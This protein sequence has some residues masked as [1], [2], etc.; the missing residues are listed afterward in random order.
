MNRGRSG[1]G[2]RRIYGLVTG[3]VCNIEDPEKR[4]RVKCKLPWLDGEV[5]TH[6]ARVVGQYAGASRG[7]MHIP[8]LE[9]EVMLAF[10]G[11]DPNKPY[12]LGGVYGGQHPVPGPGN[13]DGKNDHKYFRSRVGHDLEFLDTDG[14]EKIRLIDSS[15]NNTMIF[16][17]AEDTIRTKAAT[18]N[19]NI[20]APVGLINMECVD[21]K[22]TTTKSRSVEVGTTHTVSVGTNRTVTAT[23][24]IINMVGNSLT[25]MTA[26]LSASTDTQVDVAMGAM[27]VT[28]GSLETKVQDQVVVEQGPVTKLVGNSKVDAG[29]FF[30]GTA[31]DGASGALTM[32]A[33]ML[34]IKSGG[35]ALVKGSATTVMGGLINSKSV[36][37]EVAN[38]DGPASMAMWMGGLMLCNPKALTFPATKLVD[39]IIGLDTHGPTLPVPS[40]PPLPPIP[41]LPM[42]FT[43]PVILGFKPTVLVNFLPAAPASAVAVGVHPPPVP[44]MWVPLTYQA[45]FKAA[46]MALI[47]AP[48]S[49]MLEMA[50]AKLQA[51]AASTGSPV[52]KEGAMADFVGTTGKD[53]G[54]GGGG[55]F[56]FSSA[57]P[58]FSSGQA[59]LS[60][61]LGCIPL[62]VANA[63]ILMGS[64]S[65]TAGG[66]PMGMAM[67]MGAKSCADP[68][69]PVP[70]AMAATFSN[71]L[72]GISIGDFLGQLAWNAF[73]D[74][75]QGKYI[76]TLGKG[77][78]AV[79]R[80]IAK[81][82]NPSLQNAAQSVN[83]FM[84]GDNCI[85]EG[86]PVDVVSGTM[87]TR[88]TD[89][90]LFS[91][92]SMKYERFYNGK[93]VGLEREKTDFGPGWRHRFD[94]VL[95]ADETT[96]GV[97]SIALRDWEGRILG[98][99]HPLEDGGTDFHPAERL[100]LTRVDGRTYEIEDLAGR[101]RVFKFPG[102]EKGT[103]KGYMPGTKNRARLMAV[104]EPMGGDG[105]QLVWSEDRLAGFVDPAGRVVEITHNRE[106]HVSEI[107][108]TRSPKGDCNIFLAGYEYT[109]EGRLASHI[110]RNK[111]RRRYAYDSKGRLIKETDRN[112]YS[113]HFHYDDQ[114]RCIRTYGDDN[115]YWVE[116]D[117]MGSMT[118]ATD[119]LGGV[120]T[121]AYDENF[122]VTATVDAEGGVTTREYSEEGWLAKLTDANGNATETAYDERGNVVE[123][124]DPNGNKIAYERTPKGH[125][126]EFTDPLGN[127]WRV[128]RDDQ[129]LLTEASTPLGSVRRFERDEVGRITKIVE[130]GGDVKLRTWNA[131]GLPVCDTRTDGVR[132][133]YA[134]DEQG[135][136]TE[137]TEISTQSAKRRLKIK[138][139]AEGR[140]VAI[141]GPAGRRERFELLPD[142]QP[143]KITVGTSSS[144]RRYE[145]WG[146]LVEHIDPLGRKTRVEYDPHHLVTAVHLPGKRS[147]R[148]QRDRL[149]RTVH[150][151]TPDNVDVRY[152][153][154]A[155]GR[156]LEERR[157]DRTKIWEYDAV[158]NVVKLD[159]GAGDTTRFA[160]DAFNRVI[161]AQAEGDRGVKRTYDADGNLVTELQGDEALRWSYDQRR[162][163]SKRTSTWGSK[164]YFQWDGSG[165]V[166]VEDQT[167]N[168]HQFAH[169]PWGN[170]STWRQPGG[171]VRTNQWDVMGRLT[172]DSLA[173]P[174]GDLV[175]DRR[176]TWSE[177]DTIVSI[178]E[179]GVQRKGRDDYSYDDAGRLV[180]WRRDGKDHK[181]EFDEADN[182]L[183]ESGQPDRSYGADRL[184]ED[185]DGNRYRYDGFG[186]QVAMDGKGGS[187]RL[188]Y[189][190]R[191][192][193]VRV[194]MPDSTLVHHQYDAVGRRAESIA[195]HPDGRLTCEKFY[196]DG[197]NLA[198][199]VVYDLAT[200]DITR[201]EEYA[202][203]PEIAAQ[204]LFRVIRGGEDGGDVQYYCTDQRGAAI[205]LTD[206]D[207]KTLWS[208]QYDPYGRCTETGPEAGAQPLRMSGQVYDS[209]SE[210]SWHRFRVFD[211]MSGRFASP[212]PLGLLAGHA[213][214][215]F[216]NDPVKYADPLGLDCSGDAAILRDNMIEAGVDEP[217]YNNHAHHIVQSNSTDP[218]SVA[219]RE[220]LAQHNV[221]IND[222]D[223]G[224]FLPANT[225]TAN[226]ADSCSVPHSRI[227]TN[228]T[229]SE[230]NR[231]VTAQTTE[232][233]VRSELRAIGQEMQSGNWSTQPQ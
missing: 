42:P 156:V 83:D 109:A 108:L 112:G 218:V 94:E 144:K 70:N 99:E 27:T 25:V 124:V 225:A 39:T 136:V 221:S 150:M 107:R 189:D 183:K 223:N 164:C 197:S 161:E 114:N 17:T 191:D 34:T 224:V 208:A 196:W 35:G 125:V 211:P 104:R 140:I 157:P 7:Q 21:L 159:F 79:A 43:G 76:E 13:P 154:D 231:R 75:A 106:G 36:G 98:F 173:V 59:F 63:D 220:H 49:A 165:L 56:T 195:E 158:G 123:M 233:G 93:A 12:V 171:V 166:G 199:R 97:R 230:V 28:Q 147:W 139:D 85:S 16:D 58:M 133:E 148:Y 168:Q 72:V 151:V 163:V 143:T 40:V 126:A 95:V 20:S 23:P 54:G 103:G 90:E 74:Y 92:Q 178:D 115:S 127:G 117:Y 84:G 121:Y 146:R 229:R 209:A 212:D 203:D 51:L 192:R 172:A 113:F 228:H 9:D 137:L 184:L 193:V 38:V 37:M 134:Y 204:P 206:V 160:Y 102:G 60:F 180:G 116:L 217:G 26:S 71:C 88:V 129:G 46:A 198:R 31:A 57:F 182:I 215:T 15:T 187:R 47:T 64:T 80:Q 227:H 101:V 138:R 2:G 149:G 29:S 141:D 145:G 4:G 66:D 77:A 232:A 186:R 87:F 105:I 22:I 155:A 162:R 216:P 130:G 14:G 62:P 19:I 44:W 100:T 52:F 185:G 89:F 153:Y 128:A 118:K 210:L 65:V 222:A 53:G 1:G 201:D 96:D 175:V 86:H 135:L 226:D 200:D 61:I 50:K 169:D 120:T 174:G 55:E 91:A 3:I 132:I 205:Q 213:P 207:G 176:L 142:G 214:Y 219:T 48:F 81:T 111:N 69:I 188:W 119:G 10:E 179:Q 73:S 177:N 68:P 8:E 18:G 131:A 190:G 24:N 45:I 78:D 170:R 202:F 67:P 152:L 82:D 167:G 41:M 110:D 32:M 33:G 194:H 181:Y 122:R 5:E 30:T 6:W 11:G